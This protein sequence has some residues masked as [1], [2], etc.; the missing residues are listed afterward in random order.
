[1]IPPVMFQVG[2][3]APPSG[4]DQLERPCS[5]LAS[6]SAGARSLFWATGISVYHLLTKSAYGSA[7]FWRAATTTVRLRPPGCANRWAAFSRREEKTI[8]TPL[9][10]S[11]LIGRWC[12]SPSVSKSPPRLP[13]LAWTWGSRISAAK[14]W[15]SAA[16]SRN[17]LPGSL[18]F[19]GSFGTL[20]PKCCR[21]NCWMRKQFHPS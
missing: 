20:S 5:C 17:H 4:R 2:R 18:A 3:P 12:V 8:P 9:F 14:S 15:V 1:M 7:K 19:S 10:S 13:Y 11:W 6:P 21:R 16:L